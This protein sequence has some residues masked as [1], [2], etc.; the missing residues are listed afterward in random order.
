M[1]RTIYALL[2]GINDYLGGVTGLHGCVNDVKCMKEFLELRT[3]GGEFAF[4]PRILTSGDPQNPKE[5]KPT[6]EAVI[7]GFQEHL[8]QAGPDDIALFYYSGHGSQEKAPP[9][10]WHLEP[11]HLDETVVCYDSRTEGCWDLAD[12]ELAVLIAET[13]QQ[14]AHVLVIL[15]S[16]HSGSGTRAADDIGIR[17]AP[18][19]M[20]DRPLD[21]FLPGVVAGADSIAKAG[22]GAGSTDTSTGEWFTLPHGRHVVISACRAEESAREKMMDDGYNH[23][24]LSY[25]LLDTVQQVGPNLSYRDVF[26]RA[27]VLVQ[28]TVTDQN[29]LI[30][31]TDSNDLKRPFLG[32]AILPQRP[33][34]T[35]KH[36]KGQGWVLEA[37]M[38]H[39]IAQPAGNETTYLSA[40]R[41]DAPLNIGDTL[42]GEVGRA[43]VTKVRATESAVEFALSDDSEPNPKQVYKAVV[44]ATPLVP[45]Q[46]FLAGDDQ[47]ALDTLRTKLATSLIVRETSNQSAAAIVV[48][49]NKTDHHY[50]MRR[51]GDLS[52]LSIFV[53]DK[54]TPS[55]VVAAAARLEHIAQWMQVLNLD[56]KQSQLPADAVTMEM[57]QY[58]E[59]T[60]KSEP[61]ADQTQM[62]L[63]C[64][65]KGDKTDY[66]CFQIRVT[67]RW[68]ND[69]YCMLVDLTEDFA[70]STA[71]SLFGS[72]QWLKPGQEIWAT[73][74]AGEKY[75]VS[76]VPEEFRKMGVYRVRDVLKLIV[77]TDSSDAIL[78]K[79]DGLEVVQSPQTRGTERS[80][81]DIPPST[82]HRLMQRVQTR[83]AGDK[84]PTDRL[85]DWRTMQVNLITVDLSGG[86]ALPEEIGKLAEIAD[87]LMVEG[88]PALRA[89]VQLTTLHEGARDVGNLALPAV[90]KSYPA[91]SAPFDFRP[92]RGGDAGSSVIILNEVEQPEAVTPDAPL[93]IHTDASLGPNETLLPVGY[94]PA[95]GLYLPL[96][97]AHRTAK[98]L[99]IR[100]DR[101]PGAT[102]D[103]RDIK[104]SIKLFFQKVIGEKLGLEPATTRLAVATVNDQGQVEYDVSPTTVATRVKD[105]KRILLYIHGFTGDTRG[106]VASSRGLPYPVPNPPPSLA[107]H[108]DLILAYDYEN[109][110]TKVE[111][112]AIKLKNQLAAVGLGA[113]HKKIFHIV[114]HSLGCIV[115]R[116]FIEREGGHQ[117]VRK[118]VLVGPPNQGTPWAKIEDWVLFGLGAAINGL[119]AVIWPPAGI[120]ALVGTL[121]ILV[122]GIEKAD[123]TLDQLKPGSDFYLALN[124]SDDP[125]VPYVVIAGNTARMHPKAADTAKQEQ[126]LLQR[127]AERLTSSVTRNRIANLAFF[128]KAN[129]LAISVDSMVGLPPGRKPAPQVPDQLA[130]D[131]VSYF[132]DE[133]GLRAI[134]N[135]LLKS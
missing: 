67:N 129:D 20:R 65:S 135:E 125:K 60:G 90:F 30:A 22:P 9:Q 112:T 72:G 86:V 97:T 6:R 32:G 66:A 11:D 49:A 115:T 124:A 10:F 64:E 58:N 61:F 29:P 105:A 7:K 18:R 46:V 75:V 110:N 94:D 73:Q 17:L 104:G 117:V 96:G 107:D 51:A 119:A 103:S 12:K 70:V 84:P 102:S 37:G 79:Q 80:K 132:S 82:L 126:A 127:L 108:Y 50:W 128:G 123:T 100:I 74:Q 68:K 109:I 44:I 92:S 25:Y 2:V 111:M 118:A 83:A 59:A 4:K 8:S 5:A 16:C 34:F 47:T 85:S 45:I 1:T 57:Y 93:L 91:M 101:L 120:P 134:A 81:A 24:V 95:S 52:P 77:S 23:G 3:A 40:F 89:H 87:G 88:H 39:G 41:L 71:H 131:H 106:M 33:Y 27:R 63:T 98:G 19:D 21:S 122:A 99:R 56:N 113:G 130:C 42:T 121:S 28:N 116:W 114:A 15:D 54:G 13:A 26:S 14:D 48:T 69:L 43:K 38:M 78:L 76:Y 62:A 55:S 36:R 31:A 35:L 53:P 133:V